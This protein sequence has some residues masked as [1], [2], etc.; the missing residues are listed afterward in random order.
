MYGMLPAAGAVLQDPILDCVLLNCEADLV[1]IHELSIDLPLAVAPL[2]IERASYPRSPGGAGQIVK[3]RIRSGVDAVVRYG[4]KIHHN[5][6]DPVSLTRGENI[7]G[8]PAPIGLLQPVLE[9]ERLAR[10]RGEINDHISSLSYTQPHAFHIHRAWQEVSVVGNLP[11]HVVRVQIGQISDE[12][13]IEAR[14]PAVQPTEAVPA[15]VNVKDRLNLSVHKEFV[16]E[17]SVEIEQVEEQQ[18]CVRIEAPVRK[19]HRDVEI[20]DDIRGIGDG[21]KTEP[22]RLIARVEVVVQNIHPGQSL[23]DILRREVH[24]VIVVPQRAHRFVYVASQRVGRSEPRQHVWIVLVVEEGTGKLGMWEE[25]ARK[26][27]A[28]RRRVAVVQVRAHLILPKAAVV[29]RQV[30]DIADEDRL[31]ISGDVERAGTDPV[32]GP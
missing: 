23:V 8:W 7:A 12:E 29:D 13:L 9:V 16:S 4:R 24:A 32:E 20:G 10:E 5:L 14:R 31:P 25:V 3:G 6:Q 22:R 28:V 27:V 2:E 15:R 26:T 17:Y 1:A 30:I 19:H 21:R 18:P 11:K